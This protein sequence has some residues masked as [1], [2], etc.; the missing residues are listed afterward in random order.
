MM[1]VRKKT[2]KIL[3]GFVWYTGFLALLIKSLKLFKEAYALNSDI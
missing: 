3:A 1:Y 2:L